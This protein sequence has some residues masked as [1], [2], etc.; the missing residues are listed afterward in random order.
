M[1][2]VINSGY[3]EIAPEE[4]ICGKNKIWYIPH[5]PVF[6]SNKPNK[7]RVVY[8]CGAVPET[9]C[10]NDNLMKDTDLANSLVAVLLRFRRWLVPIIADIETMF[11]QV[12]VF[13]PVAMG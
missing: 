7:L 10:L 11:Y 5:H 3:D 6:N 2:T 9:K 1:N 4:Q 13:F 8:N 12:N